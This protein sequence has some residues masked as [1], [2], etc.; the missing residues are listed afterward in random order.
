MATL[1]RWA[2]LD[3]YDV[4]AMLDVHSGMLSRWRKDFRDGKLID[5]GRV[6]IAD[7]A[8]EKKEFDRIAIL[9]KENYRLKQENKLLKKWQR[10]LGEQHQKNINLSRETED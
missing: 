4:A 10:I 3:A 6:K 9:E 2:S 7:I 1:K 5:D 8:E